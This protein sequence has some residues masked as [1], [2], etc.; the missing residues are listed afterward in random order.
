MI[1]RQQGFLS[2]NMKHYINVQKKRHVYQDIINVIMCTSSHAV[3][4]RSE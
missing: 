4:E 3:E 1:N 2:I